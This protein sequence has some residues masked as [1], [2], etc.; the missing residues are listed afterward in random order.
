MS[1][2]EAPIADE[3]GISLRYMVPANAHPSKL[4]I[5]RVRRGRSLETGKLYYFIEA[6]QPIRFSF[7]AKRAAFQLHD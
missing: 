2:P 6:L 3:V 5:F 7:L 4:S 1:Q